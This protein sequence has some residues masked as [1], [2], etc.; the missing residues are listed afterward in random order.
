MKKLLPIVL[1]GLILSITSCSNGYDDDID[2]WSGFE[3][4]G[5]WNDPAHSKY[6]EFEG[7]FNPI[8]GLWR[9]SASNKGLYFSDDFKLYSV[10]FLENGEYTKE[11]IS[12]KYQINH[13]SIMP[14]QDEYW[15]YDVDFYSDSLLISKI[16]IGE[17][18]D[19]D[20]AIYVKINEDGE[21]FNPVVGKWKYKVPYPGHEEIYWDYSY[22]F[23]S[24]FTFN[25]LVIRVDTERGYIDTLDN[26]IYDYKI[27]KDKITYTDR[28][29]NKI[30]KKLYDLI[31]KD[32][33]KLLRFYENKY[34][35][36]S[37]TDYE[38]KE[39]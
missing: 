31:E 18:L 4:Q 23:N 13:S 3:W 37:Y 21:G 38:Q 33:K 1:C 6:G 5:N 19:H 26:N 7:N 36:K 20:L 11:I 25:E 2:S 35:D 27:T 32:N 12:Q 28:L 14:V 17:F 34:K 15:L 22:K 39:E 9:M 30:S 24:D 16:E 8:N 10:E 29:S